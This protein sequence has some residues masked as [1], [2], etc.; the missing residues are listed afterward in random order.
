MN[1]LLVL[2][3]GWQDKAADSYT[4]SHVG[5]VIVMR[6]EQ[7]RNSLFQGLY[8]LRISSSATMRRSSARR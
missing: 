1:L 7:R 2:Y 8:V 3:D 5:A 6:L 4:R